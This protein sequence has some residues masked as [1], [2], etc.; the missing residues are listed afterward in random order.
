MPANP[1]L[2]RNSEKQKKKRAAAQTARK[3]RTAA[4]R[5]REAARALAAEAEP[6]VEE[7]AAIHPFET[8][9]VDF[10]ELDKAN[11]EIATLIKKKKL[12]D[13][14][15]KARALSEKFPRHSDGLQRLADVL[16]K[17]GDKKGALTA[18]K[19]AQKR[20]NDGDEEVTEEI[21]AAIARLS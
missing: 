20:P 15:T 9:E 7:G 5:V 1:G 17:R 12:D 14:E 21:A 4:L 6:E 2:K 13:A 19:D 3:A 18:L 16:E 10:D 8:D 11:A